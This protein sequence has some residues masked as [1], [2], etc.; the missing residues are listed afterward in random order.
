MG[1]KLLIDSSEA[2]RLAINSALGSRVKCDLFSDPSLVLYLDGLPGS[3]ATITDRSIIGNDGNLAGAPATWSQLDNGIN[4]IASAGAGYVNITTPTSLTVPSGQGVT[5]FAWINPTTV[6]ETLAITSYR[7]EA[8]SY[9]YMIMLVYNAKLFPFLGNNDRSSQVNSVTSD[10][11]IVA[12]TWQ[13]V[14]FTKSPEGGVVA[15]V[16]NTTKSVGTLTGDMTNQ[17][18]YFR[19]GNH[20]YTDSSHQIFKGTWTMVA[21]FNEQKS[22]AWMLNFYNRTKHLFGV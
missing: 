9:C 5:Q 18:N 4:G 1:S 16:N 7:H 2:S 13:F 10:T 22:N 17:D 15:F 19:V 14:G 3:G 21:Q 6:G 20:Y 11:S 12:N 8:G